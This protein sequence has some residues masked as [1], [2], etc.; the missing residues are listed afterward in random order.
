MKKSATYSPENTVPCIHWA[1]VSSETGGGCKIHAPQYSWLHRANR[2]DVDGGRPRGR[3][4]AE[5]VV[6]YM[7]FWVVYVLSKLLLR[8]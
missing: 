7:A 3:G 2:V 4:F 1:L 5:E 8:A 6:I